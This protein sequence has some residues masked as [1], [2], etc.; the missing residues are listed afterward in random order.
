MLKNDPSSSE[1]WRSRKSSKF[2]ASNSES[3]RE[4]ASKEAPNTKNQIRIR[5]PR[6]SIVTEAATLIIPSSFACRAVAWR[7]RVIRH[8][9][10]LA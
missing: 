2:Q 9:S 4:R 6:H 5:L 3:F 10:F 7:R 1:M 8:S